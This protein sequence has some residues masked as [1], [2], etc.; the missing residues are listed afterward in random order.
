[1]LVPETAVDENNRL[2]RRHDD[3]GLS[4]QALSPQG[5]TEAPACAVWT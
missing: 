1:M 2:A 3:I 5:E 4:R